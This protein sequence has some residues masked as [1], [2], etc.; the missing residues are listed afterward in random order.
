[1][2]GL[3][4]GPLAARDEVRAFK[5]YSLAPP[6]AAA[7]RAKLD[8]NESPFDVP[9]EVKE[10]VLSRLAKRRWAHYPEIGAPRLTEAIAAAAGRPPE[11][12]VVGNG[13]GELIQ[14]AITVFAGNGGRLLLA[15]PTFSMYRQLAVLAGASLVEVPRPAPDFPIDEREFLREAEVPGTLPLVCTPNN[16][17]GGVTSPAFLER[18]AAVSGVVLADQAYVDFSEPGD[19]ARPLLDRVENLVV[20]RTLSK[21]YSAAGFRIGYALAP[22]PVAAELRKGVLPFSVD[23]AAEELAVAL[24]EAPGL[25]RRT[26]ETVRRERD[27]LAAGLRA[28]GA[29]VAPSGSNFLFF[30]IPGTAGPVLAAGLARRGVL[31][32]ELSSAAEGYLR[33]TVGSAEENT[34]FLEALREAR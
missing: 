24:L 2:T 9:E 8:F 29:I 22:A 32:R 23:A 28:Q 11:E 25:S 31:V 13:S 18:L 10:V 12:V 14:A 5:A 7:V 20:F 17:T 4:K 26:V 19:D 15:P 3:R 16:P 27:G 6:P 30:T 1:M 34:I 33:V 21:A